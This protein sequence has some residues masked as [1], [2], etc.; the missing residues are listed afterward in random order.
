M[1]MVERASDSISVSLMVNTA[2]SFLPKQFSNFKQNNQ[3]LAANQPRD[4]DAV[5]QGETS[6]AA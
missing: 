1:S 3:F 4:Y 2:V 5:L 6:I